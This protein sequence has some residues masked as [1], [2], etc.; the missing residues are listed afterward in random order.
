MKKAK[1]TVQKIRDIG[2]NKFWRFL[3]SDSVSC[4]KIERGFICILG[5][6]MLLNWLPILEGIFLL[7]G[8]NIEML[9]G[10]V[11]GKNIT[12]NINL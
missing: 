2:V 3:N 11:I 7:A 4:W 9:I 1:N 10:L 8:E 6:F 12:I 5:G